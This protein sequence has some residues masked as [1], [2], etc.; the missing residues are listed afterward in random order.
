MRKA[1]ESVEADHD[2]GDPFFFDTHWPEVRWLAV[3][4]LQV[5]FELLRD[6]CVWIC[7]LIILPCSIV[8]PLLSYP[9]RSTLASHF[10]ALYV[11]RV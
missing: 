6:A 4:P 8:G 3:R 1:G 2:L 11:Q 10:K 7:G 5:L 9:V